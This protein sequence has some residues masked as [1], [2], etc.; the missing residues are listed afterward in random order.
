MTSLP[1]YLECVRLLLH[2]SVPSNVINHLIFTAQTAIEISAQF[3]NQGHVSLNCELILSGALLLDI[4]RCDTHDIN[5]G[6]VGAKILRGL[7]FP[8]E[9]VRIS[10]IHLFAGITKQEA[11]DLGLPSQDFLHNGLYHVVFS[12]KLASSFHLMNVV[13]V[14]PNV[15]V[16]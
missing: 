10:E 7:S 14:F 5:H 4:G 6:L 15:V 8:E 9:L 13:F 16:L 12:W 3:K 2:H 11:K 1:N